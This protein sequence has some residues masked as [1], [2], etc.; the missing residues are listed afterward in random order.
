MCKGYGHESINYLLQEDIDSYGGSMIRRLSHGG[1]I[2]AAADNYS[3]GP[4]PSQD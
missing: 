4:A 2:H 1:S 3:G